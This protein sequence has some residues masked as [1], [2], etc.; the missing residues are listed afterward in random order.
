[1]PAAIVLLLVVSLR[2][3]FGITQSAVLAVCTFL[4]R[5]PRWPSGPVY[6]P[7]RIALAFPLIGLFGQRR[8]F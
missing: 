6:L 2:I 8:G 1:M 4:R 5:L 7:R 3:F